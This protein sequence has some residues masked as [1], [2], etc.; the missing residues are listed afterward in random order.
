MASN[1]KQVSTAEGLPEVCAARNPH[2][3][4]PVLLKRGESG[5]WPM[6]AT[7]VTPEECNKAWGVTKAQVE[8]MLAGSLFG[9]HVPGADPQYYNEDGT[10]ITRH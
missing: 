6:T 2:D 1:N 3:N 7:N 4:S 8:A 9:W 5:F 10:P